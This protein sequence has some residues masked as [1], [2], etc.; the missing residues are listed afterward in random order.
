M[1]DLITAGCSWTDPSFMTHDPSVEDRG[2]W[3]MWPEYVANYVNMNSI[4][5]G[6]VGCDNKY[7][8]DRI[9]D[10]VYSNNRVGYVIAMMTSWDRVSYMGKFKHPAASIIMRHHPEYRRQNEIYKWDDEFQNLFGDMS[11]EDFFDWI[12][13]VIDTNMRYIYL[14]SR[15][16]EERSMPYRIFQGVSTFPILLFN[17]IGITP[18]FKDIHMIQKISSNR[19]HNYI[20]K[21]KNIIGFPF[22]KL[23]NGYNMNHLMDENDYVSKLDKHPNKEAQKKIAEH[24]ISTL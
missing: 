19:Y 2:P 10:E 5:L 6:Q 16:C 18:E 7:I 9:V 11:P 20:K 21:N 17:D 1:A 13:E 14:L 15:F 24:V 8:F 12:S 22:M 23:F 3:P 4:N